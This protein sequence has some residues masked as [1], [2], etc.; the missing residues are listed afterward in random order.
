MLANAH[1]RRGAERPAKRV[2]LDV[3]IKSIQKFTD[4]EDIR[5]SLRTQDQHRL[6][7]GM[8]HTNE[9][10]VFFSDIPQLAITT[11]RNQLT[12][13]FNEASISPQDERLLLAQK[14]LEAVPGAHD[15]FDLWEG[16]NQVCSS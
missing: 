3:A 12:V 14:W 5:A 15:I 10:I 1:H 6:S 2:K 9:G 16:V 11:L 7:E 4:V 13:K 8:F